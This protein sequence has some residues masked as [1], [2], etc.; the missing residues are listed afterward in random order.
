M[1]SD[2]PAFHLAL[3]EIRAVTGFAARC[4]LTVL[5]LYE[6]DAPGDA[7]P[8]EAIDVA[9][10]FAAGERRTNALRV[11]AVDALRSAKSAGAPTAE[12]A[13]SAAGHA[14]G[15]AY[16]HPLAQATQVRHILGSAA[17]A[18]RAAELDAGDDPRVG[19]REIERAREGAPVTVVD[20]L[21]RYPAAPDG[22]GRVGELLRLL[23]A[24]LRR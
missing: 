18:A 5:P 4:A 2:D 12:H 1:T 15:A 21:R 8:R 11:G 17:H 20:V 16:L 14:S 13:A 3:D 23:D 6:R 19:A 24:A 22:G 10:A 7:V 9:L